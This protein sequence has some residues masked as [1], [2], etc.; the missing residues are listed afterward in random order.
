MSV[1][2]H[3]AQLKARELQLRQL[4]EQLNARKVEIVRKVDARVSLCRDNR[5]HT[6]RSDD[7]R[8][9]TAPSAVF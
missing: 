5:Q 1:E 4:D 3:L 8:R 2:S 7:N 9:C 6:A